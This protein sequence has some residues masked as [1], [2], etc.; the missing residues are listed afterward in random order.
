MLDRGDEFEQSGRGRIFP[1]RFA[2]PLNRPQHALAERPVLARQRRLNDDTAE[3]E[4][5]L[6]AGVLQLARP[7]FLEMG[8]AAKGMLDFCLERPFVVQAQRRAP[9]PSAG[10]AADDHVVRCTRAEQQLQAA[11][12]GCYSG[13]GMKGRDRRVAPFD[14][15]LGD[16][17]K[18]AVV[19]RGLSIE[20]LILPLEVADFSPDRREGGKDFGP[21]GL[22]I[23]KGDRP[24]HD[25][26]R[27]VGVHQMA[28]QEIGFVGELGPERD[29]GLFENPAQKHVSRWLPFDRNR[30]YQDRAEYGASGIGVRPAIQRGFCNGR[31]GQFTEHVIGVAADRQTAA[32]TIGVPDLAE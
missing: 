18:T 23:E 14:P 3:P 16:P 2:K 27:I 28:R 5:Q 6:H 1:N 19:A 15:H 10:L 30:L 20:P 25:L 26:M 17:L 9:I 13:P 21:K 31:L 4:R 8:A 12:R 32:L 7:A 22:A 24:E 11:K 29:S